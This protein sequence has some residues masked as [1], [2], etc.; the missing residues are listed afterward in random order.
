MYPKYFVNEHLYRTKVNKA[1]L[2]KIY[3]EI[4]ED[5]SII[6]DLLINYGFSISSNTDEENELWESLKGNKEN[7]EEDF[8]QRLEA[9]KNIPSQMDI[10]KLIKKQQEISSLGALTFPQQF[11]Q[12]LNDIA[13]ENNNDIN[14]SQKL[15]QK[16][17][18]YK[19]NEKHTLRC[20]NFKNCEYNYKCDYSKIKEIR[21]DLSH[22]NSEVRKVTKNNYTFEELIELGEILLTVANAIFDSF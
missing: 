20:E 12:Q 7:I 4:T 19:G 15:R 5:S 21:N 3:N 16:C 11:L 8:N 22:E 13:F 2:E 14:I 17:Q 1:F 6:K 10:Q 18:D 9:I